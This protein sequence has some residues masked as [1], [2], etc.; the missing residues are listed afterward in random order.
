MDAYYLAGL[1][2]SA[3]LTKTG[4]YSTDIREAARFT[5]EEAI[6]RAKRHKES[7]NILLPVHSSIMEEIK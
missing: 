7:S 4:Q 5:R 6:A 2:Q 3:W 1:R